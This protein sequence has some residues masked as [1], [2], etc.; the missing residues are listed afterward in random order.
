MFVNRRS[1]QRRD[2]GGTSAGNT[3]H[4]VGTEIV[5]VGAAVNQAD[6]SSMLS[7]YSR[8]EEAAVLVNQ[9]RLRLSR[10]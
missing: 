1:A 7:Q 9:Y 6:T 4:P 5:S 8:A 3:L 2:G 10:I